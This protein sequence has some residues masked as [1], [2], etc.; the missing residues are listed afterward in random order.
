MDIDKYYILDIKNSFGKKIEKTGKYPT[1]QENYISGYIGYKQRMQRADI[2]PEQIP[3]LKPKSQF[4]Q[5][6]DKNRL[7]RHEDY[8][9]IIGNQEQLAQNNYKKAQ[10]QQNFYTPILKKLDGYTQFRSPLVPQYYNIKQGDNLKKKAALKNQI[11]RH[12]TLDEDLLLN[13][14]NRQLFKRQKRCI[15]HNQNNGQ[16][17]NQDDDKQ[18]HNNNFL[19]Q[20]MDFDWY[21]YKNQKRYIKR[22]TI[23]DY[24]PSIYQRI[25]G[26]SPIKKQNEIPNNL[27][28]DVIQ[29]QKED[30]FQQQEY[31]NQVQKSSAFYNYSKLTKGLGYKLALNQ[32]SPQSYNLSYQNERSQ[33][34]RSIRTHNSLYKEDQTSEFFNNSESKLKTQQDQQDEQKKQEELIL[35]VSQNNI[36]L[37]SQYQQNFSPDKTNFINYN[38]PLE[39]NKSFQKY[40]DSLNQNYGLSFSNSPIK[41]QKKR[42]LVSGQ[43]ISYNENLNKQEKL[44][45]QSIMNNEIFT[46]RELPLRKKYSNFEHGQIQSLINQKKEY[47]NTLPDKMQ[48]EDKLTQIIEKQQNNKQKDQLK[49]FQGIKLEKTRQHNQEI[50][51]KQQEFGSYISGSRNEQNLNFTQ[52]SSNQIN[53][54]QNEEIQQDITFDTQYNALTARNQQTQVEKQRIKQII[55]DPNLR[56][57]EAISPRPVMEQTEFIVDKNQL[58]KQIKI[59]KIMGKITRFD[60]IKLQNDFLGKVVC[61]KYK[62]IQ[63]IN[64][65]H[66]GGVFKAINIKD[67]KNSQIDSY[68][69]K[70]QRTLNSNSSILIREKESE[71]FAVKIEDY[72]FIQNVKNQQLTT[73]QEIEILNKLKGINGFPQIQDYKITKEFGIIVQSLCKH[74]LKE[75]LNMVKSETSIEE[76]PEFSNNT[77]AMIGLQ[78]IERLEQFHN[79]GYLHRDLKP[80]NIMIGNDLISCNLI[81]LID[82]GICKKYLDK[83]GNHI[84]FQENKPFVGTYKYASEAAIQGKELAYI[85]IKF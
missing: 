30:K 15:S 50:N 64:G 40:N 37:N 28:I 61:E 13:Q 38:E 7:D 41:K 43:L 45:E 27:L 24:D 60:P 35:N 32:Q 71:L 73:K 56:R 65:G 22:E 77:V 49:Q 84:P 26:I 48:A 29:K 67:Q 70:K 11:Q 81:H 54:V 57:N 68:N 18:N 59:D 20:S 21:V 1:K 55:M 44:R 75:L 51:D 9:E 63:Y 76:G 79:L 39:S 23:G 3:Y 62:I 17:V 5:Q 16:K 10:Q 12:E 25:P 85:K 36:L 47:Q 72:R 4:D 82:F 14:N 2:R 52:N 78:M 31:E 34:M 46:E 8:Q 83:R 58:E 6:T 74:N 69:K 42:Q 33:L 80:E 53:Y 19:N 66:F